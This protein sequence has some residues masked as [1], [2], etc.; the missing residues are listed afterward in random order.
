MKKFIL[1]LIA[2][3]ITGFTANQ[4]LAGRLHHGPM[5]GSGQGTMQTM[6]T[7]QIQ[8]RQ[9]FM[10]ETADIRQNLAVKM[11]EYRALMAGDNPSPKDAGALAGSIAQLKNQLREKA[12]AA[13][14]PFR[15]HGMQNGMGHGQRGGMGNCN[16]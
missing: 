3:A 16:W 6:T 14:V 7:E 13:G 12:V 8:A 10:L 5:D 1:V 9:A 4:V 15:G 11:G 2:V